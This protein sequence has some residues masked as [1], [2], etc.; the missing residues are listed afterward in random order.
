M[1]IGGIDIGTTG[2]KCTVYDEAGVFLA[3]SYQEYDL[4][5]NAGE[6]ELDPLVVWDSVQ[7]VL[8]DIAPKCGALQAIGVTSFGETAVLLDE[9]DHP[10]INSMLYTDTRGEKECKE[11]CGLLGAKRIGGITGV[12][13]H[14]MYTLPKLM[15]VK[16]NRPEIFEQVK[17]IV[18][19]EDYI[20]YMLTGKTQIDYSLASRTMAFD[21]NALQWSDEILSKAGIDKN[22]FS[23]VVPSGTRAALIKREWAEKLGLSNYITIVSGCHDQVAAAI[24]V[25]ALEKGVAVD[26]AGTVECITPVLNTLPK[27]RFLFEGNYAVVPHAQQG[28]YVCYAFSFT[29]GALLKWYRDNLAKAEAAAAITRGENPY[30]SFNRKVK[31]KPS[32]I[33]ILPY[34][35]GAATPYMDPKATGAIVGLSLETTSEDIYQGLMEA[36]AF[37]M[38]V[39]IEWLRKAGIEI[40]RLLATGGGAS[41]QEWLQ[42]K[43]DILNIPITAMEAKEAGTLGCI[44]LAGT[45][46]GIYKD[47]KAAARLFVRETKTFIPCQ[48]RHKV[49]RELYQKYKKMYTAIRKITAE[50]EEE[51]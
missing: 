10:L 6:H 44:M 36:V 3:Q 17:R 12:K 23:E 43:A 26:G 5:R 48:E 4:S 20:V 19:F 32:G 9:F 38:L 27:N 1:S 16:K 2:C 24:G 8:S 40:Q 28:S 14:P 42:L 37:E 31:E 35:A 45:A 21:I 34:F 18:L 33:L 46:C 50:L 47:L 11:L 30:E 13:P 39:N 7:K 25:G 51:L 41:S 49:Y 15:W 22:L 29:G